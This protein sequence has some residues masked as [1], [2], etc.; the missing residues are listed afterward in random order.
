ME[1]GTVYSTKRWLKAKVKPIRNCMI[2]MVVRVFLK[3]WGTW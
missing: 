1:T 2:C 3:D